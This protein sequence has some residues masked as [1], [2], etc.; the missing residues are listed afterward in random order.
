MFWLTGDRLYKNGKKRS[1]KNIIRDKIFKS[2][3]IFDRNGYEK[4]CMLPDNI[5][6]KKLNYLEENKNYQNR[7]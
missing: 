4:K 2:R 6:G 5:I 7:F 3:Y 1:N